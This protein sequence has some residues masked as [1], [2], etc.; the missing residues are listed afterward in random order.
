VTRFDH[1]TLAT[2]RPPPREQIFL[3][4]HGGRDSTTPAGC[5][6]SAARITAGQRSPAAGT[7]LGGENVAGG[8]ARGR[9]GNRGSPSDHR[10]GTA[11]YRSGARQS[12]IT[13]ARWPPGVLICFRGRP[14]Y[15]ELGPARVTEVRGATAPTSDAVDIDRHSGC[16][17]STDTRTGSSPNTPDRFGFPP[18]Q[19]F[20]GATCRVLR[21]MSE[22]RGRIEF[23]QRRW[24]P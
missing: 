3:A 1:Y 9:R 15:G 19:T 14:V 22:K 23:V 18:H 21:R 20:P 8:R 11:F 5:W 4:G 16:A 2:G 13:P 12:K 24:E 6:S 17:S 10:P 7:E